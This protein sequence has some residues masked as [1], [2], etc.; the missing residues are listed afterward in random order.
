MG[1][2]RVRSVESF[3]RSDHDDRTGK[4]HRIISVQLILSGK[5]S[6]ERAI[7][8]EE[9]PEW[10]SAREPFASQGKNEGSK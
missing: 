2:G 1:K 6:R 9:S 7:L 8:L 10:R 5:G 4:T 3:L